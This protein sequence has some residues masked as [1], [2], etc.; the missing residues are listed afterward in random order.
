MGAQMLWVDCVIV[1]LLVGS[2]IAGLIQGFFRTACSLIGLLFGY[3]IAVWNYQRSAL[4]IKPLVR[5]ESVAN[6]IAFLLIAL[7]VMAAFRIAGALLS[8]ALHRFGLG[9]LDRMA[10]LVLGFVQG[11]GLVMIAILVTVAFY[12]GA[13]WLTQARLP[14]LF[15]GALH[16]SARATPEELAERLRKGLR[17]LEQE[18]PSWMHPEK[19]ST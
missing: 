3:A 19:P 10:G 16:V 4:L 5:I 9:C 2:M 12:P 1:I 14:K 15:F 11:V 6:A 13:R 17:L 18:S 8:R 7:L